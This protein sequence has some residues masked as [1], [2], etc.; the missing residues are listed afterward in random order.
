MV[1]RRT[2]TD[3][4]D[5]LTHSTSMFPYLASAMASCLWSLSCSH[6]E[7]PIGASTRPAAMTHDTMLNLKTSHMAWSCGHLIDT[8]CGYC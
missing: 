8:E 7:T 6:A 1:T 3:T 4:I 2:S 5:H